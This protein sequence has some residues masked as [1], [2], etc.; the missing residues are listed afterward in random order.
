MLNHA[1]RTSAGRGDARGVGYRKP[2]SF[3]GDAVFFALVTTPLPFIPSPRADRFSAAVR[4]G[5]RGEG[6][7]TRRSFREAPVF[8]QRV[9]S[10]GVPPARNDSVTSAPAAPGRS[11]ARDDTRAGSKPDSSQH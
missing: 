9:C 11:P 2:R 7:G 1:V 6:T 10:S 4:M 3:L 8:S 5:A